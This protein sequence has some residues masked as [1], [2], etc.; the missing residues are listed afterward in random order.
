VLQSKWPNLEELHPCRLYGEGEL[1]DSSLT[2]WL[3]A[4]LEKEETESESGA[5]ASSMFFPRLISARLTMDMTRTPFDSPINRLLHLLL[6][7][8]APH[9][10]QLT[11]PI[12][13]VGMP[14]MEQGA[15]RRFPLMPKLTHLR[16]LQRELPANEPYSLRHWESAAPNLRVLTRN[17][18]FRV[19]TRFLASARPRLFAFQHLEKL[20]MALVDPE[21]FGDE[22]EGSTNIH[23]QLKALLRHAPTLPALRKIYFYSNGLSEGEPAIAA[24]IIRSYIT[25]LQHAD[26]APPPSLIRLLLTCRL[27]LCASNR[28]M[29][30]PAAAIFS[31]DHEAVMWWLTQPHGFDKSEWIDQTLGCRIDSVPRYHNACAGILDHLTKEMVQEYDVTEYCI[32][33]LTELFVADHPQLYR[34]IIDL[35]WFR[36][37]ALLVRSILEFITAENNQ[38]D[39]NDNTFQEICGSWLGSE[40]QESRRTK[41]DKTNGFFFFF[42]FFPL[43][44]VNSNALTAS[45]S[46]VSSMFTP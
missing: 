16:V 4:F 30:M 40:C 43:L 22:H 25:K 33:V 37:D 18:T 12:Q 6:R 27:E 46:T 7:R 23:H 8:V 2:A 32:E 26:V 17:R 34:Q 21:V 14:Y 1:Y 15:P 35:G 31:N 29:Q 5:T 13:L 42:F 28:I 10:V 11:A 9:L 45:R 39:L 36:R 3:N 41:T 24:S 44:C 38:N 20:H 19:I